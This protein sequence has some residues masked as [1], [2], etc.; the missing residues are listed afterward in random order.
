MRRSVAV[1]AALTAGLACG[2]STEPTLHLIQ[3]GSFEAGGFANWTTY[4]APGGDQLGWIITGDTLMP[5]ALVVLPPPDSAL[6]AMTSQDGAGTH[7]LYQDVAIP[8]NRTATLRV[9][10]YLVSSAAFVNGQDIGLRWDSLP[11]Q[12]FRVDVVDPA[13]EV[14]DVGAG[15]LLNVYRTMPGDSLSSGYI[16]LSANLTAFAGRTVRIRFAET[17]NQNFLHAGVDAVDLEVTD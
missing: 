3:N 2:D 14:T 16:E 4:D 15:V 1:F 13:A 11:N 8:A 6:G 17:D 7:V 10:I 5:S 12:Q 9:T